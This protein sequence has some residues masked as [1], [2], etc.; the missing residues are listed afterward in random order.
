VYRWLDLG[1]ATAIGGYLTSGVSTHSILAKSSE[2][3][4]S[5][6]PRRLVMTEPAERIDHPYIVSDQDYC[7]G[8]PVIRG[9]KFPVR[10]VVNY[11]LRQGLSPEEIVEEF[12]HLTLAQIYDALSY[13]YDNKENIDRE[14]LENSE[15]RQRLAKAD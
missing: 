4:P 9:T 14:L 10:S 12:S 1:Q 6:R 11:V 8:S 13:Y 3:S 2:V 5:T 15:E 7:G